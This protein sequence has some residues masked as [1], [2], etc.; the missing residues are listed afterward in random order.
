MERYLGVMVG[1]ALVF[2]AA[3]CGASYDVVQTT[4]PSTFSCSSTF[5]VLPIEYEDELRVGRKSEAEYLA[6]KRESSRSA[7]ERDKDA[8]DRAFREQL[9]E[10]ASQEGIRVRRKMGADEQ[11]PFLI[12]P[13]VSQMEPGFFAGAVSHASGVQMTVQIENGA[14]HTLEQIELESETMASILKPATHQRL[15]NDGEQL[16]EAMAEYLRKRVGR[17]GSCVHEL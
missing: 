12:R 9:I 8:I 6:D 5:V 3:G 17:G 16:G 14:G 7:W 4:E 2:G 1:A 10:E 13:V 15:T 11:G